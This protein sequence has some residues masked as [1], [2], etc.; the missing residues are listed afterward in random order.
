MKTGA[1]GQAILPGGR[2]GWLVS[3]GVISLFSLQQDPGCSSQSSFPRTKVSLQGEGVGEDRCSAGPRHTILRDGRH[4]GRDGE[5][6]GAQPLNLLRVR[7]L[8]MAVGVRTCALAGGK[9]SS[10][11]CGR[12]P[13]SGRGAGPW[14]EG[15]ALGWDL[16]G[17]LEP[18][19]SCCGKASWCVE[20]GREARAGDLAAASPFDL[21]ASLERLPPPH[22]GAAAGGL[23]RGAS[24]W[25]GAAGF[26]NP[27]MQEASSSRMALLPCPCL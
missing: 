22:L 24:G 27:G 19:R 15:A 1:Q 6:G 23:A 17:V 20:R 2:E 13:E 21:L 10:D 8:G 18:H 12:K 26:G 7:G 16:P 4:P 14:L 11:L 9:G 25:P 5:S 3:P